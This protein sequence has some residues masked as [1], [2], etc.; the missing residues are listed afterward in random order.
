M[1][2]K[3][4]SPSRRTLGALLSFGLVILCGG[5]TASTGAHA[6]SGPLPTDQ[7]LTAGGESAGPLYGPLGKYITNVSKASAWFPAGRGAYRADISLMASSN[8]IKY[9]TTFKAPG[10]ADLAGMKAAG[11]KL[12]LT[13][14]NS[15]SNNDF[16]LPA[17]GSMD[18]GFQ[19]ALEAMID[20][21]HPD[22]LV[23][24]SEVNSLD[25]YTGTVAEFQHLMAL[26]HSV[27]SA[28][29]VEDGGAALMGS[30]TAQAT[31]ADILATKGQ[32]AATAFKKAARMGPFSRA[33]ANKANAYIDACKAAG[34][35]H[36]VWHSY[37]ANPSAIL[38]IK[39]Y[40]EKRFGGSSFINELGWRT[41]SASTGT[42]IIDALDDSG[43]LMVLL[44]GSGEGPNT[45][46]KLWDS[47]GTPTAEGRVVSAH[48]LGT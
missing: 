34:V 8:P 33:L 23:Y 45:P 16:P 18:A 6:E 46:D 26:G 29:G 11:I 48:L 20:Q 28:R 19:K 41:G 7:R 31:Y 24:G 35:D 44:Y 38:S 15:A 37:F 25:K 36:F 47:N 10:G 32:A 39:G 27:A 2:A 17:D 9:R 21:L 43:I 5:P 42:A 3:G 22:Y 14:R 4:R 40:V 12:V 1:T 13:V 30:V